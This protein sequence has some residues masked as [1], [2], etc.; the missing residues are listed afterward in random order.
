MTEREIELLGFEKQTEESQPKYHYYTY[1]VSD[2]VDFITNTSD[3]AEEEG[4]WYVEFFDYPLIRFY[5]FE[6]FQILINL[7]EKRKIK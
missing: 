1:K 7:L 5:K 6:E 4:E 3:E 2:G